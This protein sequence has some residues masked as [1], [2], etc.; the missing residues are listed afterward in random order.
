[1]FGVAGAYS[2]AFISSEVQAGV[3]STLSNRY[4]GLGDAIR[5]FDSETTY[6]SGEPSTSS[7][8]RRYFI[9]SMLG[10]TGERG[11]TMAEILQ[12]V[13]RSVASDGTFPVG[14]T[15]FMHTT[16]SARSAPRHSFYP[17]IASK[18]S[19]LGGMAS[20]LFEVL[21]LTHH[22]CLG[23]MTGWAAPDIDGADM[24]LLPGSFADHLTS[25]A[26]KFDTSS[27]TKMSRWI[28]RGASATSG[29][30]EEPC[31]YAGKFPH[32]LMHLYYF[33]G[34]S[35]GEAWMRSMGYFPFQNLLYGDPLTRPFS[36][37]PAVDLPDAPL[38]PVS[39]SLLLHPIAVASAPGADVDVIEVLV[40]GII[41]RRL[42]VGQ[43]FALHTQALSDGWHDLRI[44]AYDD[45]NVRNA[46]RWQ[47]AFEVAN[48][49]RAASVSVN[50]NTGDQNQAFDFSVDAIGTG[51]VELR[52]V[53]AGRVLAATT[54]APDS[55]R[56]YG[57][58]LGAGPC[59]VQ[60][61]ALFTD[62]SLVRSLPLSLTV[63]ETGSTAS[64]AVPVAFGYERRLLVDGVR[65]VEL[66][67]AFDDALDSASYV[68]VNAPVQ[69]TII[70]G[71]SG[72]FRVLQV[73]PNASGSEPLT[74][75]VTTAS[76]T[77]A[78]VTIQLNYAA[79]GAC[80]SPTNFC[81]ALP[82][83]TGV[84]AVIGFEGSTQLTSNDL[85]ITATNAVPL[86]FGLFFY[87]AG[88]AQAP[89]GDGMLCV[90]GGGAGIFR[91]QPASSSD[92]FGG[93]FREL[94]LNSSQQ[95]AGAGAI[96]PGST[97]FFQ[98]WYRD[99]GG[100]S[101]FNLSDGLSVEFCP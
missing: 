31:N 37:A 13:D 52:L 48:L 88:Q 55:L 77:S 43:G 10:Y 30:V 38:A 7:N 34:L 83:S 79:A 49:G 61:E 68:V 64:A 15:Y 100:P 44:L 5:F 57:T 35:M 63:S 8:A 29:A 24:T 60:L 53:Q 11:N 71:G 96:E 2:S 58:N 70:G 91:L 28:S 46:G 33:N 22:D 80:P 1:R 62:G 27:Q 85:T 69:A 65:V 98:Y 92:F 74:F 47:G 9:S 81:T 3:S 99:S 12:M 75:H 73:D 20:V 25:Y 6:L 4:R 82:N 72:P 18:I 97:W 17:N 42:L 51:V 84:P 50:T 19:A 23:I 67:A 56:L 101:G 36:A 94:D 86:Q 54:T 90:S 95:V 87:G 40:D 66:P 39:G 32:A 78:D 59:R 14:T 41:F 16:D 21:P 89:L 26:G 45:T 93:A 76:G